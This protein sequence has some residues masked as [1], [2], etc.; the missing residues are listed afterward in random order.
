MVDV[1]RSIHPH[2]PRSATCRLRRR[3]SL[4]RRRGFPRR[5]RLRRSS[6]SSRRGRSRCRRRSRSGRSR[7]CRSSRRCIPF[8]HPLVPAAS[9]LFAGS[10]RISPIL[11]LSGSP[12]RSLGNRNLRHQNP[13]RNRHQTNRCLHKNPR[14]RFWILL[15][16][17]TKKSYA[18]PNCL[19]FPIDGRSRNPVNTDPNAS[20]PNPFE[21]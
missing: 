11:T 1:A 2:Q 20:Q 15:R 6:R 12:C 13:R 18:I 8:L 10:R 7:A 16:P 14:I 5:S 4:G 17:T 9:P 19:S 21:G 3:R